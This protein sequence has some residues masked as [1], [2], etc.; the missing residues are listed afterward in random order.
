MNISDTSISIFSKLKAVLD[1]CFDTIDDYSKTFKQEYFF[2]FSNAEH[3][4]KLYSE[5]YRKFNAAFIKHFN[6][7]GT[8]TAQISTLLLEA[9]RNGDL[10][11]IPPLKAAFESFLVVEKSFYE[12]SRATEKELSRSEPSISCLMQNLSGLRISLSFFL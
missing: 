11:A 9:D 5:E 3:K 12:Y 7:I 6:Q 4:A 10:E 2:T 8:Y 1:N